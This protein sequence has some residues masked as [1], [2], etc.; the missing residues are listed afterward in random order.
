MSKDFE[1]HEFIAEVVRSGGRRFW[2]SKFH[3]S[4]DATIT[5]ASISSKIFTVAEHTPDVSE[6]RATRRFLVNPDC[7]KPFKLSA[8]EVVAILTPQNSDTPVSVQC[9]FY[10][11]RSDILLTSRIPL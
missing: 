2:R 10:F 6:Y 11:Y 4:S 5:M 9:S 8:G 1:F 3:P 7:L